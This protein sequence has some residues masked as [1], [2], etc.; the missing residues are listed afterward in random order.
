MIIAKG[1][2]I[3][4]FSKIISVEEQITELNFTPEQGMSK[5][6]KIKTYDATTKIELPN[7]LLK[8]RKTNSKISA[9]GLTK[10]KGIFSYFIDANCSYQL[11]I[12]R[13]GYIPYQME[14]NQTKGNEEIQSLK[15]PMFQ[16]EKIKPTV[17][18]YQM[19]SDDLKI[20]GVERSEEVMPG[21][22]RTILITD[23]DTSAI[24]LTPTLY[25]C[26]SNP[27][28]TA[29]EEI[30][31][32]KD[33]PNHDHQSI[34]A[35]YKDHDE[36]GKM[37]TVETASTEENSKWFRIS[38]NISSAVLTEPEGFT[39]D[40]NFKNTLQDHNAKMLIFDE[41]KLISIVYVP[42]YIS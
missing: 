42:N 4:E 27:E 24:F 19:Y 3:K 36:F 16:I 29:A 32:S 11:E 7:V 6:L 35:I 30:E 22:F 13:K 21:R 40:H 26:V 17:V 41:K 12:V 39:L 9:E 37:I 5:K 38:V 23:H 14:F 15:V 33:Y 20:E 2:E 28:N 18:S 1:R 25:A 8:L 34:K 31:I 10:D